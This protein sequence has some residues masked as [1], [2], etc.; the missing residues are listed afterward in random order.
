[1]FSGAPGCVSFITGSAGM[2]K[3]QDLRKKAVPWMYFVYFLM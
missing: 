2:E 1:M 3:D